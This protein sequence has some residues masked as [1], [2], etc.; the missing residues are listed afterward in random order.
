[1]AQ[2]PPP[3]QAVESDSEDTAYNSQ[4]FSLDKD[5][6]LDLDL[7]ELNLEKGE[8]ETHRYMD[9]EEDSS[10]GEESV[11]SLEPKS[12]REIYEEVKSQRNLST[13][14]SGRRVEQPQLEGL[15]EGVP[16]GQ[17]E[18]EEEY[19]PS[20]YLDQARP[21]QPGLYDSML[22]LN[23]VIEVGGSGGELRTPETSEEEEDNTINDDDVSSS[24]SDSCASKE[25]L[26]SSETPTSL[27]KNRGNAVSD[28]HLLRP[29]WY[30]VSDKENAGKL[31]EKKLAAS[32]EERSVSV[33]AD[34]DLNSS[35]NRYTTPSSIRIE[36][37][38][39]ISELD[40]QVP[41]KLFLYLIL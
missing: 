16:A 33:L 13:P 31:Y 30:A 37:E 12:F 14:S 24:I 17:D 1:M 41:V 7:S 8:E 5:G 38:S 9:R 35:L 27:V 15:A 10:D 32:Y 4:T 21:E 20:R 36:K 18:E 39:E 6:R 25:H 3:F 26:R 19:R 2:D 34:R 29:N 28:S 22:S 40:S 23:T 11:V